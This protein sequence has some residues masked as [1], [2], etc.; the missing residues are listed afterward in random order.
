MSQ[1]CREKGWINFLYVN[2]IV[3]VDPVKVCM[4]ETWYLAIDM[5]MFLL[6]PLIIYPLWR[7]KKAG[8]AWLAM[9]LIGTLASCF[10]VFDQYDL[11][12]TQIISRP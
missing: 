12:A 2:N 5:Q 10:V 6:S 9:W 1:N 4:G 11:P 7:W 3:Q 8:L